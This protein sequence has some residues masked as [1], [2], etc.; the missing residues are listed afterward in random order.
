VG[1]PTFVA[2]GTHRAASGT[3]A[4]FA[5]PA[6]VAA[7]D[8]IVIPMYL[9][10]TTTIT[11]MP[12]GFTEAPNSP[13]LSNGVGGN[14]SLHVAWKRATGADS[15][16]Y[17]FTLSASQYCT[18][19]ALSYSGCATTGN[20]WD[21]V[22]GTPTA[23]T[24]VDNTNSTTTPALSYTTAGA[25]RKLFFAATNWTGGAWTPPSGFTERMD[26]G[27]HVHTAADLD[28]ATAGT[29]GP[30]TATCVGNDKRT[31][32]LG[33]LIG[34][35]LDQTVTLT[36]TGSAST[37]GQPA[38]APGAVTVDLSGVATAS[39]VGQ[40]AVAPGAVT[41]DLTGTASA[42]TVG[43][44][45][46][47]ITI[48]L[49]GVASASTIGQ[50][51]VT[52]GTTVSLTGVDSGSGVGQPTVT[53]GTTVSLTGVASASGIGQPA[54][55]QASLPAFR[56]SGAHLSGTGTGASFAVPAGVASDDIIIIPIYVEGTAA[57]T[58]MPTGFAEA[59]DSPVLTTG[60]GPVNSLHVVWKRA[61]AAD[62]GTY[63]FTFDSSTYRAGAALAYS[64]TKP[65]GSPWD[66]VAGVPHASTAVDNDTTGTTTPPVSFTT[67]GVDRLLWFAA[68]D[69]AG[70]LWSSPVGF[71]ERMDA[72]DHVH[73]AGELAAAT[74]GTYGPYTA[75]CASS[76]KR[77][78]WLGALAGFTLEQGVAL[79]GVA[80]SGGVGQPAVAA[81]AV[82]VALAGVGSGSAV[83]VPEVDQTSQRFYPV[84]VASTSVVGL[85]TVVDTTQVLVLAGVESTA[86]VGA[87]ALVR[88]AGPTIAASHRVTMT[89]PS[90]TWSGI[91]TT[92]SSSG[93]TTTQTISMAGVA[94]TSAYGTPEITVGVG[95][96]H[97]VTLTGV[98]SNSRYGSPTVAL[99][100]G[101]LS[102]GVRATP[103]TVGYLGSL[104][105]LTALHVGD[106]TP[107]GTFWDGSA[108]RVFQDNVILDRLH[109]YG[110]IFVT[111]SDIT[112]TNC[113]IDVLPGEFFGITVNGAGRGFLTVTDTTVIGN[114]TSGS[115]Q[116]NG[117]SSD[118]GLIARRC[119]V[120][121]TGDGIHFNAITG[122]L[123]SQCY[124]H[125]LAFIDESQHCD[126]MQGFNDSVP[127]SFTVEHCY[128]GPVFSTLGTPSNS[129]LTF[130]PPSNNTEPLC[131][132]TVN[133]NFFDNGLY[134]LRVGYRQQNGVVTNNDFGD[135]N[136]GE[137]GTVAVSD[138][139]SVTTWTNN[140]DHNG[141]L[142]PQP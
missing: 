81:G 66:T 85:P 95:G 114:A 4:D 92:G 59:P 53:T 35:S 103:G 82:T 84:G 68:S 97:T 99:E 27:D 2:A 113:V 120:S 73:T 126:G 54:V 26:A 46:V 71:T 9:D 63:D 36:G 89:F 90:A 131:T 96:T 52:T 16:T 61:T 38:V 110:S 64:T 65:S 122:T 106:P 72:G 132:P 56:A 22:A 91:P 137:F 116:V 80:A 136:A 108:L 123:V 75:S 115:P 25:D 105:A 32:W 135:V 1:L 101:Q 41:V 20:P 111:A 31:A 5:V 130:G 104:G 102:P 107:T 43:A 78:V 48:D 49:S 34:A 141:N 69:W 47:A 6:G 125:D 55:T 134:H 93:G 17:S 37:V 30:F 94:S 62:T 76:G 7:D 117:I 58:A 21:T 98:A 33:A 8:I 40:P 74:A 11:A 100:Q 50:P 29:Y 45:A 28:E 23:S 109:V 3:T 24:A 118:S 77:A 57:I 67:T 42:S 142:I 124:V 13:V 86:G 119:D 112:V 44:P 139:P 19:S 128:V 127:G 14:H 121:G 60:G 70:G 87:P 10:G 12:T 83:G 88:L 18:G 51:T 15:G 129:A 39:A 138:P 133:N 140:R 79:S